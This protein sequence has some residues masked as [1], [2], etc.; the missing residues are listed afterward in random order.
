MRWRRGLWFGGGHVDVA[1]V[2]VLLITAALGCSTIGDRF[3]NGAVSGSPTDPLGRVR[4]CERAADG[5]SRRQTIRELTSRVGLDTS[6]IESSLLDLFTDLIRRCSPWW[7]RGG[8]VVVSWELGLIGLC[9]PVG[10]CHRL[11]FARLT[12]RNARR[13]RAAVAT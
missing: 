1:S 10:V 5:V 11:R 12:R 7:A 3:M 9:V 4:L 8:V 13:K 2:A 6:R